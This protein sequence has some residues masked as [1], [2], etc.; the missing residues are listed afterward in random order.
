MLMT[1]RALFCQ[2][3][4]ENNP[5]GSCKAQ[6]HSQGAGTCETPKPQAVAQHRLSRDSLRTR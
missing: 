6:V 5:L 4:V 1:P 2:G 3:K